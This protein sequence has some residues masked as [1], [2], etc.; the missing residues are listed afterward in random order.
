MSVELEQ[1]E[2]D[3]APAPWANTGT[4]LGAFR[5]RL[6]IGLVLMD[7]VELIDTLLRSAFFALY[8]VRPPPEIPLTAAPATPP[9]AGALH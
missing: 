4:V 2:G 6:P 9:D 7:D 8:G 1:P 5:E 3:Q